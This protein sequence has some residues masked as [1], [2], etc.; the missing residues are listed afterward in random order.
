MN[1]SLF[2]AHF[3]YNLQTLLQ[4][5]Q[6]KRVTVVYKELKARSKHLTDTEALR[7]AIKVVFPG[8]F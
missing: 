3:F 7:K 2:H 6:R 8:Y 4:A 5:C 1:I